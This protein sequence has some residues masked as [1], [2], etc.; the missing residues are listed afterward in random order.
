MTR[1]TLELLFVKFSFGLVKVFDIM[2]QMGKDSI[3][4]I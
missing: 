1:A 4:S 3:T 2:K